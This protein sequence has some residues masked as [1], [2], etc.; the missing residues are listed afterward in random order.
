MAFF[1]PLGRPAG[2]TTSLL[3]CAFLFLAIAPQLS[4]ADPAADA[5]AEEEAK[6]AEA[7]GLRRLTIKSIDDKDGLQTALGDW[8]ENSATAEAKYGVIA[9]W[10]VTKV[11]DMSF[12]IASISCKETFNEPL[13]NW[14]T[15]Q[16]TDMR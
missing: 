6:A 2:L 1:S 7:N 11:I 3:A 16:V 12:L 13:T 14:A 10:D 15:G 4:T 9:D 8:C 5:A